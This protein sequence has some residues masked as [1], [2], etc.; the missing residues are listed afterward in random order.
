MESRKARLF[1]RIIGG[2]IHKHADAPHVLAL[3]RARRKR[4][5][6]YS[7]KRDNKFSSPHGALKPRTTPYHIRE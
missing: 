4:P 1:F 6:R 7:A 3:L 5:R 2:K